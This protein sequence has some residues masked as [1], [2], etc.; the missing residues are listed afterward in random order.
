[1]NFRGVLSASSIGGLMVLTAFGALADR[2]A[3][4]NAS[5]GAIVTAQIRAKGQLG[6]DAAER[7]HTDSQIML[8]PATIAKMRGATLRMRHGGSGAFVSPRGLVITSHKVASRCVP[9]AETSQSTRTASSESNPHERFFYASTELEELRCPNFVVEQSE[10][11]ADVSGEVRQLREKH[12][13]SD[14]A[15]SVGQAIRDI[16]MR[17]EKNS[18]ALCW[19]EADDANQ[20]FD[21]FRTRVHRDVRLVF[22]PEASMVTFGGQD[23]QFR[24]PKYSFDVAFL[25]VYE[26][27]KP[28]M[29]PA[30]LPFTRHD[31]ALGLPSILL[32][33]A[34]LDE[35][36]VSEAQKGFL[37]DIVYPFLRTSL[38]QQIQVLRTHIKPELSSTSELLRELAA[39][40][41]W[42]TAVDAAWEGLSRTTSPA[43][44]M[45][46]ANDPNPGTALP[47]KSAAPQYDLG[48]LYRQHAVIA[49]RFGPTWSALAMRAREWV[50]LE[51][52]QARI[53]SGGVAQPGDRDQVRRVKQA[54]SQPLVIDLGLEVKKLAWG[55]RMLRA[56]LGAEH[57]VMRR[58]LDGRTPEDCAAYLIENTKINDDKTLRRW[59][60]SPQRF[61]PALSDP[62]VKVMRL[63]EDLAQNLTKRYVQERGL[64]MGGSKRTDNDRL[65]ED[66]LSLAKPLPQWSTGAFAGIWES[67]RLTPWRSQLGGVYLRHRRAKNIDPYRLSPAWETA[68][69]RLNFTMPYNLLSTHDAD[70]AESGAPLV[71]PN[72]NILALMVDVNEGQIGNRFIDHGEPGR[73]IS[74]HATAIV[75]ILREVYDAKALLREVS[76]D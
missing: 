58:V 12:L 2:T 72:G 54:L 44:T 68:M 42:R 3:N 36:D 35:R 75:H 57:I 5:S 71:D 61:A 25:R 20:R 55:L 32:G 15:Q 60:V 76:A 45:S 63:L 8:A 22:L 18:K 14:P 10:W 62:L 38:R 52:A 28:L 41:Y 9:Q 53:R 21:L 65:A 31:A 1:M 34:A 24:F 50:R 70:L 17:C 40:E 73:I 59:L 27:D 29:T 4:P 69:T 56:Q 46:M 47:S 66:T 33:Y 26:A 7:I 37:K 13:E 11:L 49:R 51:D 30:Y 48:E 19:V 6:P 74:L 16:Q 64:R 39:S 23:A 67:A 43:G